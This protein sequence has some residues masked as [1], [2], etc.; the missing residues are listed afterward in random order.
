VASRL[1]KLHGTSL[2]EQTAR[3]ETGF[4]DEVENA[5]EEIQR[6]PQQEVQQEVQQEDEKFEPIAEEV[7]EESVEEKKEQPKPF[8]LEPIEDDGDEYES[9]DFRLGE[10][11]K[12]EE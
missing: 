2:E 5:R 8:T 9:V 12:T 3:E 10:E 1:L 7:K 6:E 4:P 11:P